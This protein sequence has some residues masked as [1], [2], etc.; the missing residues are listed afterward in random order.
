MLSIIIPVFNEKET[1]LQLLKAVESSPV[2]MNKEIVIIDDFSTDG[3]REIL[4]DL[5]K[6]P[7]YKIHFHEKNRGKG[8]A[9]QTGFNLATGKIIITQDADLEYDPKDYQKMIEPIILGLTD[10]SYGSRFQNISGDSKIMKSHYMGN[11]LL[12]RLSNLLSGLKLTDMETGYKAFSRKALDQILPEL[13]SERF[14]IEPELTARIAKKK[15][16]LWEVPISYR[17]RSK[18]EGKKMRWRDGFPALWAIIK[19]NL[20]G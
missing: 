8:K 11:I 12:T 5:Q 6:N 18:D 17:A 3:T 9:L 14:G 7:K 1:F 16:R 2:K 19:F 13:Q 15:L 4:K 10:V 20:F